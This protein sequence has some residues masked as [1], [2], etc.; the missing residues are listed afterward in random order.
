M[1]HAPVTVVIPVYNGAR[2][3]GDAIRSVLAQTLPAMEIV[4]VDDGSTDA[5]AEIAASFGQAVRLVRQENQGVAAARNRGLRA[6]NGEYVAWLDQDDLATPTRIE[7]QLRAFDVPSPPDVVF[8]AM[9]QFISPEVQ[10]D[11]RAKLRCDERTQPAPLPSCFM[12]PMRVFDV[13]GEL[14]GSTDT[15]FVDWY[16]RANELGLEFHYVPELITLRR[17]HGANRSYR[18]EELRR[19]YLRT[20]KAALDRR[21][22][23]K[24][25]RGRR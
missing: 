3:L 15:T 11:V 1:T 12:A 7:S 14:E 10:D 20:L 18:N 4:V 2:Y 13:V 8:G 25:D 24:R 22:G 21:R 9:R 6:A 23:V 19:D 5:S 16:L 17:I